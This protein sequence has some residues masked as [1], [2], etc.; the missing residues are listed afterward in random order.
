MRIAH[1]ADLHIRCGTRTTSRYDEYHTVFNRLCAAL[2]AAQ[3]DCIV[4]AGDLFHS[5]LRIESPGLQLAL[6]L[7]TNLC[8]IAPV[9]AIAGNHD[10]P[11]ERFETEPNLIEVIAG[12]NV[13]GPRFHYLHTTGYHRISIASSTLG[14]GT[15]SIQDTLQD[16][17]TVEFPQVPSNH[18]AAPFNIAVYHG[19]TFPYTLTHPYQAIMLGD[20]HLA[21]VKGVHV[22]K[23]KP[24]SPELPHCRLLDAYSSSSEHLLT[25]YSG[26]VVQQDYGEHILGHGFML[27]DLDPQ[28]SE[29]HIHHYHIENDYGYV[30][31]DT[32]THKVRVSPTMSGPVEDMLPYLPP[33][34]SVRVLLHSHNTSEH[35]TTAQIRELFAPRDICHMVRCAAT[36]AGNDHHHDRDSARD[37]DSNRDQSQDHE[38]LAHMNT[39]K[40]WHEFVTQHVADAPHEWFDHPEEL[41]LPAD[42]APDLKTLVTTRNAKIDKK[43]REH[44]TTVLSATETTCATGTFRCIYMEWDWI[45]CYRDGNCF[46]F[47]SLKADQLIAISARN[48][49][50]KTSFLE[51]ICLA[52]FGEGFPSRKSAQQKGDIICADAPEGSTPQT[53]IYVDVANHTFRIRR[54]FSAAATTANAAYVDQVTISGAGIVHVTQAEVAAGRPAVNTWVTKHLGSLDQFLMSSMITQNADMDFFALKGGEQREMLDRALNI[55]T[56]TSFQAILKE[57]KLAHQAVTDALRVLIDT[58]DHTDTVPI[59][60]SMIEDLEAQQSQLTIQVTEL[61]VKRDE[62]KTELS[63][64]PSVPR[65]IRAFDTKFDTDTE[66][67]TDTAFD[68]DSLTEQEVQVYRD[69]LAAFKQ[70]HVDSIIHEYERPDPEDLADVSLPDAPPMTLDA[71]ERELKSLSQHTS[72]SASTSTSPPPT[73]AEIKAAQARRE[74]L[75]THPV[76]KPP[77]NSYTTEPVDLDDAPPPPEPQITQH[78]YDLWRKMMDT[79]QP[80]YTPDFSDSE[81]LPAHK[82]AVEAELKSPALRNITAAKPPS[83]VKSES[84][85]HSHE[86]HKPWV[87]KGEGT[88][89]VNPAC[90]VCRT[91]VRALVD[92]LLEKA[93]LKWR[94]QAH[95]AAILEDERLTQ[96]AQADVRRKYNAYHSAKWR[97]YQDELQQVNALLKR[98]ESCKADV[99]R[100]QLEAWREDDLQRRL[101]LAWRLQDDLAALE[102]KIAV[103]RAHLH[104][105][106]QETESAL[107][108]AED[109]LKRTALELHDARRIQREHAANAV[110]Y[111]ARTAAFTALSR[112]SS[113]ISDI[114]DA[115]S[116]FKAWLYT[117]RV[118]PYIATTANQIMDVICIDRPLQLIGDSN[119]ANNTLA[120]HLVDHGA[121]R[122]M[123]PIEKASGFQRFIAGLSVRLAIGKLMQAGTG[124]A[125]QLFIDEG[126]VACDQENRARVG[127]FL[128][129]LPHQQILIV[130]HLED[131][132]QCAHQKVT[133]RREPDDTCSQL[134]IGK[135]LIKLAAATSTTTTTRKRVVRRQA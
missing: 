59:Q 85:T 34:L 81:D 26:S 22:A 69:Q 20:I 5:K 130:S 62:L 13:L 52:L 16:A 91:R 133:I 108:A 92:P 135:P 54:N 98:A 126:F 27:W 127:E 1:L 37:R 119:T 57:S 132:N 60:D 103:S 95:L 84:H 42:L 74:H 101:I 35:I 73:E 106:L 116:S 99:R 129:A 77:P 89:E 90:E 65:P 111:A 47:D 21:S 102:A 104:T 3:P 80:F 82:A 29:T 66:F 9:V 112:R 128:K 14:V 45:L 78:D 120:W 94:L 121:T 109:A 88:P 51:T 40:A 63:T 32:A 30:T 18:T 125:G 31:F 96:E 23:Q 61:K 28:S 115:F 87:W 124:E 79:Y 58:M 39:P 110:L 4:L 49:M 38:P 24:P 71:I 17:Q 25:A 7:F 105:K 43:V 48:G 75:L 131:V 46:N 123:I 122:T 100:A 10:Q 53:T 118:L 64:L 56:S 86:T 15:V 107:K 72:T 93:H 76:S 2:K 134:K 67:D 11:R 55:D 6:E 68:T 50:G 12:S 113:L 19:P 97:A 36:L 117:Q 70:L 114:H 8:A 41:A 33:K 83:H 44:E